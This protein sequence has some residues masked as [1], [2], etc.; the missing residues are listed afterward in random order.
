MGAT[1]HKLLPRLGNAVVWALVCAFGVPRELVGS[2]RNLSSAS[3]SARQFA[4]RDHGLP[5]C[6]MCVSAVPS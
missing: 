4:G 6:S 2:A 3:I 5:R 1:D